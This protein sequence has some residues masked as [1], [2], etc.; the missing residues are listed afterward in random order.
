MKLLSPTQLN[1]R[2]E[3]FEVFTYEFFGAGKLKEFDEAEVVS[4]HQ[5]DTGVG[6]TSTVNV[7]LL[8]VTR[9]NAENLIA[10]DARKT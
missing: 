5:V 4:C 10:Q 7:S 2:Y 3:G 6:N 9:P 8:S 1:Q